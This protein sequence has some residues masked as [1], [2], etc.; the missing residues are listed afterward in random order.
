MRYGERHVWVKASVNGGAP[1]DFILDTGAETSVIDSA[2]AA[3]W[4]LKLEGELQGSGAG[5]TGT[6]WFSQLQSLRLEGA[7]GQGVEFG[8]QKIAVIALNRY[9]APFFWR[10]AAGVLGYDFISRF[11]L[12]V[13][14]QNQTLTLEDP[15]GFTY[16]GK[17][18]VVPMTFSGGTPV[19]HGSVDGLE[20]D[21]RLDVGSGSS[22]DL[23]TPFVKKNDLEAKVGKTVASMGGGFGGT[24][25]M[26]AC[27]AKSFTL[28][29]FTIPDPLASLGQATTG[30]F[31]SEDYAGNVGNR[32]LD[33]FVCTFDYNG[34]KLY[35]EPDARFAAR[36]ESDKVGAMVAKDGERFSVRFVLPGSPAEKAGL[37]PGDEVRS[38]AGKPIADYTQD[39]LRR[40]VEQSPEGTK[41]A[42]EVARDGKA[43]K[44]QVKLRAML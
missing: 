22:V 2:Y 4:G 5:A 14:Y 1:E 40:L 38:V 16:T 39:D 13:D 24:F 3:K 44:I 37:R 26:L 12:T 27:R 28:G 31:A 41:L 11:V 8:N 18:Q 30:A 15:E 17:G 25:S 34:K 43:K 35:L 9:M 29:P 23:H 21:F 6:V 33:R 7:D 20:G 36:D 10:D 19:V 42:F 32:I